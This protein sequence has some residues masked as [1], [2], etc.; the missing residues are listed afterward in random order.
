LSVTDTGCGMPREIQERIFEPFFTTKQP[1]KGTGLGLSVVYGIVRQHA[2]AIRVRSEPGKGTTFDILLPLENTSGAPA[3]RAASER[4]Q[5]GAGTLLLAEDDPQVR[6]VGARILRTSGFEV[7]T[8]ADGE[9]AEA[10]LVQREK[11]IRLVIL[12]IVMPRRNGRQVYDGLRAR[13]ASTPVLF[14][15][16]YR[17]ET[18]PPELAPAASAPLLQKPYAPA[19]LVAEVQRLLAARANR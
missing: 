1:G 4:L 17:P 8:A 19:Q 2:G 16:G 6:E 7:L 9:E 13:G 15:S 18:L 12:D 5:R 11:D 14:C 10:L 3:S